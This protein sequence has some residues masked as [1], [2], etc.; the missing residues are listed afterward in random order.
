MRPRVDLLSAGRYL[1]YCT[2]GS[3]ISVRAKFAG[4]VTRVHSVGW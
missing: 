4:P 3:I 1:Q 2:V